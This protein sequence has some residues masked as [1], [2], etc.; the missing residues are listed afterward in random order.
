MPAKERSLRVDA[1]GPG[2]NQSHVQRQHREAMARNTSSQGPNSRADI[3]PSCRADGDWDQEHDEAARRR[4]RRLLSRS[5]SGFHRLGDRLAALRRWLAGERWVRRLAIAVVALILIFAGCFGGLWWRL[6]A[7]PINLDMAT[8][9][10][11]SAI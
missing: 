1:R 9:W 4:A 11:A 10:L 3:Q 5:N 7:G 6:G 2:G 8:P